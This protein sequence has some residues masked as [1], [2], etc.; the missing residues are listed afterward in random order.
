[1]TKTSTA[2]DGAVV[3]P[4]SL[5]DRLEASLKSLGTDYVDVYCLHAVHPD[6]YRRAH[7]TLLPELRRLRAQGKFRFIGLTERFPADPQHRMLQEALVDDAWDVVMVGF[8]LLNPSARNTVF[9][10]TRENNVG[11]LNMFAVRR[12]LSQADALRALIDDLI[13][14]GLVDQDGLDRSD[15][16]GFLL[17]DEHCHS[18]T[19]AAYRFCRHEP[20]I[21]VVLTGTGQRAH[22]DAN[23]D[24]LSRG[25]LPQDL[26]DRL[27]RLF[28][29]ID[30]VTGN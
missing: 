20:G 1:V 11:T 6:H 19:E 25:P 18:L 28:G 13:E 3:D 16:L 24:A 5:S 10:L 12:A 23:L 22:L 2:R 17:S 15:P 9:T 14:K 7:E 29:H 27:A 21:D 4:A 30:N 8:N 26:R